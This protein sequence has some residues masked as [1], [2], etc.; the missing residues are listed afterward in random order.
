LPVQ[1]LTYQ[2]ID[3]SK[4]DACIEDARNGMIYAY[5]FYLD[6]M[7]RNWDALVLND[8]EAVMPLTWN[9]KYG[10]LYLY[11]PFFTASLGVFGNHLDDNIVNDF[12]KAIPPKFTYFDIYLN[13][14]NCFT[15]PNFTKYERTNFVLP[16]NEAYEKLYNKFRE[17]TKRNIK[18]AEGIGCVVKKE[19]DIADIIALAKDQSKN[20]SPVSPEDYERFKNLYFQLYLQQKAVTYGVYT[21]DNLLAASCVFFFSNNRA[22]YILVGN[23]PNGK[24]MGASHALINAFIKDYAN[25]DLLLD[26]EGSDMPS[27]AFFYRSFGARE[28][29]YF[30]LKMNRLPFWMKWFKQ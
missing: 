26:F 28:E 13:H 4:W 17:N 29:K 8:Y 15:L 19:I 11:Q 6:T 24:T 2:Q 9:R 14:A 18:K 30:G 21:A 10:V 3:T 27:L 5:A 22:Y 12:L 23:H 7:A 1:Y 25:Q 20:F 16:L